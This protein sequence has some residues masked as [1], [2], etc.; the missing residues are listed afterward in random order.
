MTNGELLLHWL[1]YVAE[2]SW[3]TFRRA[4]LAV[5][6]DAD[7]GASLGQI[8]ARLS[9]GAYV[10]FFIDGSNQWRTIAPLLGGLTNPLEAVLCGGRSPRLVGDLARACERERV[11]MDITAVADAPNRVLLR[12]GRQALV[13]AARGAG[14]PFISKLSM[15]LSS[16]LTPIASLVA[17]AAQGVAPKN[18]ALR[19]FDLGKLRWV[20]GL[21]PHTAYEY[22]SRYGAKLHF[23]R[24]PDHIL[25]QLD[26]TVAVYAAA[27]FNRIRLVSY[28]REKRSLTVPRAA[29]LPDSIARVAAACAGGSA[30][31][32]GDR[33][34]YSDVPADVAAVV[35]LVL[36]EPPHPT[37][38]ERT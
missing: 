24:G 31:V 23:V 36:G 14:I 1:S 16:M 18:W 7:D 26:R 38:R 10:E 5:T 22:R 28:D 21:L 25:R 6:T 8:R 20:D 12:G 15:V 29:P 11:T 33:L 17:S 19:S 37:W 27:L 3:G 30:L 13:R 32:E 4:V 34:V 35:M 2:G 9:E